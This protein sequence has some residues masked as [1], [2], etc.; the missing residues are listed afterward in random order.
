MSQYQLPVI[1][2]LEQMQCQVFNY[3]R[4]VSLPG[5]YRDDKPSRRQE[6]NLEGSHAAAPTDVGRGGGGPWCLRCWGS[7]RRGSDSLGLLGRRQQRRPTTV[8]EAAGNRSVAPGHAAASTLV[9]FQRG[10]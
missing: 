5:R 6:L 2:T 9:T 4:N 3:L 1:L 8:G 10:G 7:D